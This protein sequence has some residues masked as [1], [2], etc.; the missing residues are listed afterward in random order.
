MIINE[1]TIFFQALKVPF[2]TVM[3]VKCTFEQQVNGTG[4]VAEICTL[5]GTGKVFIPRVF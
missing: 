4:T 5:S 2:E 1:K 3:K